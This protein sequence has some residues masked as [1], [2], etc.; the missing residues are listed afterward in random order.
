LKV[1]PLELPPLRERDGDIKL[2]A[3]FFL[4]EFSSMHGVYRKGFTERALENLNA[5]TW[6]GNVRELKHTIERAVFLSTQEWIDESDLD[7]PGFLKP[8]SLEPNNKK[9]SQVAIF[10]EDHITLSFPIKEASADLVEKL[11][12]REV[13]IQTGGN[14]SKAAEILRISRPRLDRLIREDPEFFKKSDI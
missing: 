1:F 11:L 10:D 9:H 6:E 13:L 2:L 4:A 3:E 5:K 7:F 8:S 12:A 14:K